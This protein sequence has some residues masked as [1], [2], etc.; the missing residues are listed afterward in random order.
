MGQPSQ[1]KVALVTGAGR[2]IGAAPDRLF[3]R[4]GTRVLLATR[5][6]GQLEAVS[7]EIRAAG[8]TAEYAVCDL[9][10]AAGVRAAVERAVD[11]YGRL[12]VAFNNAA[13][14]VPPAPVDQVPERD[15][16]HVC[17]VSLKGT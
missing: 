1:Q 6:Q 2:G 16:G 11:L 5:T 8:G 14:S 15:L 4:E 13:L 9:A 17:T 7:E 10:G 12:D 3:A